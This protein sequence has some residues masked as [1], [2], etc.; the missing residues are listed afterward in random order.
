MVTE[1]QQVTEELHKEKIDLVDSTHPRGTD[2]A[3]DRPIDY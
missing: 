2:R 1:Q 3:P